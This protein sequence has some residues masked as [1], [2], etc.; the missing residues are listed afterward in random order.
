ME[1]WECD[2]LDLQTPGKFED[3]YRY[4]LNVIDAFQFSTYRLHEIQNGYHRG[5]GISVDFR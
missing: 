4:L 3:N 1:V 5:I 2:L